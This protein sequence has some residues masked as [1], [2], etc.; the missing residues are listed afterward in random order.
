MKDNILLTI[1][2]LISNRPDTVEKCL[3]SLDS[4]RKN[5]P[6]E[7][8]LTDTGCGE[9]VRAIIEKYA[10]VVLE[11]EWCHDFAKARNLGVDA[12]RGEW[13]LYLDDDEWFEDTKEIEEFF[14]SGLYKNYGAVLYLQRNYHNLKGT[15]YFDAPVSRMVRLGKGVR[16]QYSIH[17][18]FQNSKGPVKLVHSYVHHYGY[19]YKNKYDKYKHSQRNLVPLL[20]E[21]E[22]TPYNL[23]HNAQL[24]QEYNAI[25]E[26][27]KSIEISLKGIEDYRQGES[28]Q[29]NLNSLFVNVV[30][31][32]LEMY[33]YED[34]ISYAEKYIA[35]E[36]LNRLGMA[37]ISMLVIVAFYE[38]EQY[39]KC[40]QY[41]DVYMKMYGDY[42][43]NE[44]WYTAQAGLFLTNSFDDGKRYKAVCFG[45]SAILKLKKFQKARKLFDEIDLSSKVLVLEVELLTSVINAFVTEKV[46]ENHPCVYMLNKLF[47]REQLH[48]KIIEHL[49]GVRR[50]NPNVLKENLYKWR[51]LKGDCWYITYLNLDVENEDKREVVKQ[52]KKLWNETK[53]ILPQSIKLGLWELAEIADIDLDEVIEEIPY[54]KWEEAVRGTVSA[55]DDKEL[56]ALDEFICRTYKKETRHRKCWECYY[57]KKELDE[58]EEECVEEEQT[59]AK[60]MRFSEL[61]MSLAKEIYKS[62]IFEMHKEVL[63]GDVQ[64]AI[65]LSKINSCMD[66]GEY[67]Q[68]IRLLRE[69]KNVLPSFA[70]PI[71]VYIKCIEKQVKRQ[72]QERKRNQEEMQELEHTIKGKIQYFMKNSEF[73]I[74]LQLITQLEAIIGKNSELEAWKEICNSN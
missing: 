16:L 35:D 45:I 54:Y 61:E 11:F 59:I 40:E 74:A 18:A 29:G 31:R 7:L 50:E 37:R 3:Q 58:L 42:C 44:D 71:K 64:A 52:F 56:Q 70:I 73:V 13:F 28:R 33:R 23:R 19:I 34:A 65:Y 69:V 62:E 36:R 15:M 26:H 60:L 8:L 25:G 67:M 12:A 5:V 51:Y 10:D 22:K 20:E 43:Q 53:S 14:C 1:S 27:I 32:Y 49:E 68:A 46:S 47:E 72:E 57:I 24:A 39:E 38:L 55:L 41:C 48:S 30:E 63:P 9:K 17:E 21:H 4:L 66:R 2:I 6:C